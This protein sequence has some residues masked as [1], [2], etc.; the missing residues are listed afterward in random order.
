MI[1]RNR[2]LLA[3]KLFPWSL[4]CLNPFYFAAR[5]AAGFAAARRG[6]GDTAHFPGLR[7]KWKMAKALVRGDWGA[8]KLLPRMLRKR[9]A[10]RRLRRISPGDVRRLILT[11]RL[12]LK[13][14]T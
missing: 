8:L 4:L 3:F 9:T 6:A 2:L 7:G 1:E 5:V 11:H 13:E 12:S 10:I 14:T